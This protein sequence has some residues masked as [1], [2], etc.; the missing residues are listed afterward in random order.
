MAL[1]HIRVDIIMV[2]N[3]DDKWRMISCEWGHRVYLGR[4]GFRLETKSN[5]TADKPY[6]QLARE[7]VKCVC[8]MDVLFVMQN[9]EEWRW[10][11]IS[12]FA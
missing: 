2:T 8:C 11:K 3:T 10:T 6:I 12:L 1:L 9:G 4:Y 7:S 5:A